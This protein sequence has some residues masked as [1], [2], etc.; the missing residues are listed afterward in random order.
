MNAAQV[1]TSAGRAVSLLLLPMPR[2]LAQTRIP[3][4][5]CHLCGELPTPTLR[6]VLC[7]LDTAGRT[8]SP[9][10]PCI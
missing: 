9:N 4:G 5:G 7:G 6:T 2:G 1:P 8:D 10:Q 3:L